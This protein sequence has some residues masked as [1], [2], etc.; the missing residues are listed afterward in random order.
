MAVA[1]AA[2]CL[3]TPPPT[4]PAF[5]AGDLVQHIRDAIDEPI[6]S[7][8]S[9][10]FQFELTDEAANHNWTILKDTFGR[11]MSR[12]IA[13][14]ANTPLSMGSEFRPACVLE[15]LL[16]QHPLWYRIR[17]LLT[18]GSIWALDPIDNTERLQGVMD[19]I[20]RGN[21]KS[22]RDRPDVLR[23]QIID[24]VTHG[25]ALSHPRKS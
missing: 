23:Q 21:H 12:A 8:A 20:E 10:L 7:P 2:H 18:V 1:A 17:S 24:D 13:G 6:P 9:P 4:G 11:S 15:P 22:A 3:T 14:Q 19:N 16:G 5:D 25:F